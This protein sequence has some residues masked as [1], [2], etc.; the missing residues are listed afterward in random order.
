MDRRER[1]AIMNKEILI[2]AGTAAGLGFIHTIFGPDHYIPFIAMSKAR[3]W[4]N[5]KT[6]TITFLCGLGHVLSSIVI[7]LVGLALGT[8]VFK[9]E[10]LESFRGEIAGWFMLAFGFAYLLWGIRQ[11]IKNVPHLHHHSHEDRASH[12]HI[13]SHTHDHSHA[14]DENSRSN[15]TPWVL[16]TIFVFGP[17]E[18][19]IPLIMYPAAKFDWV[20][21]AL[22]SSL[23]GAATITTMMISVMVPVMGLSSLSFPRLEKY[24]HAL[25]GLTIFLCGGAVTFLGL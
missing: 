14:H 24:S 20:A 19:L 21:V 8:A 9:L 25:A 1:M 4:S 3:S 13:H 6:A 22:I 15:I 23:F 12:S 18:P 17:C 5:L 2:L 11:A 7:G 10:S 16:F